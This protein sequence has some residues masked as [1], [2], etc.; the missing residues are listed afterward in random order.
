M[1]SLEPRQFFRYCEKCAGRRSDVGV[2]MSF[3]GLTDG[4]LWIRSL[5]GD[6]LQGDMD[7]AVGERVISLSLKE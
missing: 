6:K 3:R 2:R 7:S 1:R 5:T 4:E